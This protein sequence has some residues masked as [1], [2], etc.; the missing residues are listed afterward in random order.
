MAAYNGE[1]YIAQQLDSIL[2]NIKINDEVIIS[3]DGSSDRT[4]EIIRDYIVKDNRIKLVDGPQKGVV[5]NFENALEYA[6]GEIIFLCDQDDVW[7]DN[8]IEKLFDL[9]EIK[10]NDDIMSKMKKA[11]E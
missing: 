2:N 4:R 8:K 11:I 9:D 7:K 1:L 5:K 3:D 6:N 10:C